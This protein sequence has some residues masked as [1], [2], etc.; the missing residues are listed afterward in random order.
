MA[1]GG[2]GVEGEER[3]GKRAERER[4]SLDSN[5]PC[6]V[7]GHIKTEREREGAWILTSRV[8][9][10]VTSR[11]RERRTE[12]ERRGGG[13]EREVEMSSKGTQPLS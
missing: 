11:R 6:T 5:V 2:G 8:P 3:E 12:R 1:A 7:F 4:E 9:Y 10:L 13:E